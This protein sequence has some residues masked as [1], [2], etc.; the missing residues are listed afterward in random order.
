MLYERNYN[1]TAGETIIADQID[2]EFNEVRTILNGNIEAN[3]IKD[4]SITTD[5]LDASLDPTTRTAETVGD[6]VVSGLELQTIRGLTGRLYGR[7]SYRNNG[8]F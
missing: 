1:F 3:N 8:W 4:A 6:Y 7:Y 5:K 2:D